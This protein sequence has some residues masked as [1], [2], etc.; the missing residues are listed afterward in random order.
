[1]DHRLDALAKLKEALRRFIEGEMEI[2]AFVH[3]FDKSFGPFDPAPESLRGLGD[4][5]IHEYEV[6]TQCLQGAWGG[7]NPKVPR[8]LDWRYGV[9][10]E[11]YSWID[12][13]QFR[14]F[15]RET[16]AHERIDVGLRT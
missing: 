10:T 16:L 5:E 7:A 3:A 1:M 4:A 11:P 8:R 13:E 6:F 9:D 2:A 12:V 15:V 14:R